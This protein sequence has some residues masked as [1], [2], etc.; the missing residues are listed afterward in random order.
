MRRSNYREEDDDDDAN[1]KNKMV[2]FEKIQSSN[3]PYIKGITR[4]KLI[5]RLLRPMMGKELTFYE[6][7]E[8]IANLRSRQ[9]LRLCN[10]THAHDIH[11]KYGFS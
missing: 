3:I 8:I 9:L 2:I 7:L 10:Y 4:E 5:Q 1:E 6:T 11:G